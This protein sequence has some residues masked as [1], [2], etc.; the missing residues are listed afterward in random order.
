MPRVPMGTTASGK[1]SL[2]HDLKT[3]LVDLR[4]PFPIVDLRSAMAV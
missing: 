2:A 4:G 3:G 1:S